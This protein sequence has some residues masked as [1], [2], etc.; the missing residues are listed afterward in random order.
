MACKPEC[1]S[2]KVCCGN[3][4]QLIDNG[5]ESQNKDFEN[6]HMG[7]QITEEFQRATVCLDWDS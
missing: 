3:F 4:T 1:S 7:G 5:F 2:T 6:I